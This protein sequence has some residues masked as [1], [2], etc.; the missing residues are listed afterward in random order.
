[1]PSERLLSTTIP[2]GRW[3]RVLLKTSGS[4]YKRV[5]PSWL[6][7]AIITDR[8]AL[9]RTEATPQSR[10][11]WGAGPLRGS[12]WNRPGMLWSATKCLDVLLPGIADFVPG[13]L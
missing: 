3:W 10:A 5:F 8:L 6:P 7:Q 4:R 1:M 9:N 2:H 13:G 11:P 12:R